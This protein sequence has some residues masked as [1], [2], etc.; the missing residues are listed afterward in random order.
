MR[1]V[2]TNLYHRKIL[3]EGLNLKLVNIFAMLKW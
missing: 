3:F 2:Y 1:A